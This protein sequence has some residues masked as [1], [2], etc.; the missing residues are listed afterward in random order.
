MTIDEGRALYPVL[1]R[2]AYLQAGSSGPLARPTIDAVEAE[3]RRDVEDGRGSRAYVDRTLAARARVRAL[4]AA[5]LGVDAGR[6]ALTRATTDGCNIV[7]LGLGLRDEDEIV[8][9]DSEHFGL[10]GALA[11]SPARVRVARLRGRP[12]AEALDTILAEVG[13]RT[14]LVAVSHVL[15]TTGHV[16]PVDELRAALDGVQLLVDGAQSVGAIPVAAEPFD[17]YAASCHKW[18]CCPDSTGALYVRDPDAL[19]VRMPSY[20]SQRAYE[21]DGSYTAKPGAERFDNSWLAPG[22]LAGMEAAVRAH[23][24]WRFERAAEMAARCR[25]V[26]AEHLDVVTE[27]GHSTLVSFRPADDPAAVA[28]RAYEAGVIVREVPGTGL[29]RVSCGYWTN[30]EDL[31]RLLAVVT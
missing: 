5:E 28:L 2:W 16:V 13:P 10:L 19:A 31:E 12:A 6:V 27:A 21:P 11:A 4:L 17:F 1:E 7:L 20:F 30:E 3:R 25:D 18:L 8:T 24:P 9:T 23:P 26:L 14:R 22:L 29:V 15:W